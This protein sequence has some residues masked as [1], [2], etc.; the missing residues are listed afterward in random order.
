MG[1]V[2]PTLE[3]ST[4]LQIGRPRSRGGPTGLHKGGPR[5]KGEDRGQFQGIVHT[6]KLYGPPQYQTPQS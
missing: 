1:R 5:T 3:G 6:D 2:Q 4:R